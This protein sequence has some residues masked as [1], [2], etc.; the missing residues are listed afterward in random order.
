MEL[1]HI[2]K[3]CTAKFC[4]KLD[5]LPITCDA[6]KNIFCDEHYTYSGH[7]CPNSYLKNNQVPVCPLCNKPIPVALGQQPDAVVGAH[8][9]ND[10]QSDPAVSRRKVFTNRCTKKGCKNKEVIPVVCVDCKLNYCLKH[11]HPQDHACTGKATKTPT[12]SNPPMSLRDRALQA[13]MGRQQQQQTQTQTNDSTM[14][15]DEQLA[16]ALAMSMQESHNKMT[17]EE[18]DLQ[19]ARQLQAMEGTNAGTATTASGTRNSQGSNQRCDV[20]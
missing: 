11:R 13:A 12:N 2:G 17:Q 3:Q 16:R 14:S 9:D 7:N 18:L 6:C 20:Q 10:C 19:L 4:N 5:F 1:P 15:E 8:I